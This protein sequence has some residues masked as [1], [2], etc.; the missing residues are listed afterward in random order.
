MALRAPPDLLL[1]SRIGPLIVGFLI[2]VLVALMR[3]P[4]VL[5]G[6][7]LTSWFRSRAENEAVSGVTFSQ[8]LL[9]LAFD[10]DYPD[11]RDATDRIELLADVLRPV[12]GFLE[13]DAEHVH[14]Q[15]F[16]AEELL[17]LLRA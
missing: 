10:F 17:E 12:V 6:L 15:G 3:N 8:H 5:R 2:R 4:S 13:F 1:R 16:P 14:V 7:R 9:G 11:A